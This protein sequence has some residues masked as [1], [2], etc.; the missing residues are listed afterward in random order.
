MG[1]SM[2]T[3]NAITKEV[4]G[5]R[6]VNQLEE[7]TVLLKRI[8]KT[9]DGTETDRVGGKYVTFPIKTR[10]NHGIGYRNELEQLQA[11]GQ[12]GWNNVRVP[13]RYGYGR[14]HMSGQVMKLATKNYQAFSNAMTDE[15]EGLKDD[16][17]K[18]TNRVVWGNQTGRIFTL[19]AAGPTNNFV[20]AT[21]MQFVELDMV[22]DIMD[23]SALPAA[24]VTSRTITAWNKATNTITISGAAATTEAGD[25]A[26]RQGNDLKEPHGLESLVTDSTA[27][28]FNLSSTSEP[29][30]Q[31]EVDTTGGALSE[32]KMIAMCDRLK[33]NGGRPT[34]IFTDLGTNRAYFNLLTTQRRFTNTKTFDGGHK[35]L[36]FNYGDEIPV[37][38]DVDATPQRMYF[39]REPDFKVYREGDW[40]WEDTD[41]DVW[42]WVT[43]FDA[44]EA[45]LKKYWEFA[46]QRRNTQGVMT[47]IT[48][49]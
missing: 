10:R 22:I 3:V 39:L 46:V 33:G 18:D 30:W 45:L 6:I 42:K 19:N 27:S 23:A 26:V 2:T 25:F 49:G 48:S 20:V 44:F 16:I 11:A 37:V 1:A 17:Q 24:V 9:S 5:P 29:L 43:N 12:Q 4:Y 28:L 21:G 8:E 14:V 38:T 47:G 32:S 31:S 13:L 35:G 15:M 36:A 7:E 41:G 34:V 40:E